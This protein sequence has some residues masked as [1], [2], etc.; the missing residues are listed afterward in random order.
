MLETRPPVDIDILVVTSQGSLPPYQAHTLA[1]HQI[2]GARSRLET[3][4]G[5]NKYSQLVWRAGTGAW[6]WNYI[7]T[8]FRQGSGIWDN[9]QAEAKTWGRGYPRPREYCEQRQRQEG[10]KHFWGIGRICCQEYE[11]IET[12]GHWN[13]ASRPRRTPW[14]LSRAGGR[15][16]KKRVLI[17]DFRRE[18]AITSDPCDW[19]MIVSSLSEAFGLEN[20]SKGN[21]GQLKSF[22]EYPLCARHSAS[23][24]IRNMIIWNSKVISRV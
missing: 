18:K 10:R 7:C 13:Q 8:W 1:I 23:F 22:I 9:S 19:E 2:W 14:I 12:W 20:Q 3:L 24:W 11:E 6:G 15:G 17:I 21:L 5:W 4:V 16:F